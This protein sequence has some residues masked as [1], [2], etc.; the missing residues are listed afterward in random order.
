MNST[1]PYRILGIRRDATADEIRSAFRAAIRREHP[2]T[3]VEPHDDT[4]VR[5]IID[6]YRRLIDA[7]SR[8]RLDVAGAADTAQHVAVRTGPSGGG[9]S[10]QDRT[11]R[12]PVCV[13]R[14]IVRTAVT[15]SAC[16]GHAEVTVLDGP[17]SGVVRCRRCGGAGRIDEIDVCRS[18][19]GSGL[20][21]TAS[22]S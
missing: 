7:A 1:D 8:A 22:G 16:R 15:C 5:D 18:C 3:A 12:C 11:T 9:A 10:T 14:G 17:R 13:G 2:D 21:S 6:A 4:G 19:H 20:A